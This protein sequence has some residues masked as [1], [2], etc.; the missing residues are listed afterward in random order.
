MGIAA[1]QAARSANRSASPASRKP[2]ASEPGLAIAQDL[3]GRGNLTPLDSLFGAAAIVRLNPTAGF[4][5][6]GNHLGQRLRKYAD[7][8]GVAVDAA[9]AEPALTRLTAKG[10]SSIRAVAWKPDT[11]L[12]KKNRHRAFI[13][14]QTGVLNDLP[15]IV[16][17]QCAQGLKIGGKL[18]AADLMLS[19]SGD[20]AR[21]G[22]GSGLPAPCPFDEHT[23]AL[24]SAGFDVECRYDLTENFMAAVRSGLLQSLGMLQEFRGLEKAG[25]IERACAFAAQ[26]E[27]WKTLY[28]LAEARRLEAIGLLAVRAR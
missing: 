1:N 11:A 9:E 10:K 26:L 27:T 2:S 20:T 22:A 13:A 6:V 7:D 8:T 18:F 3:W 12:F 5:F 28:S 25:R 19:D 21:R 16:Y 14:L 15:G 4:G 23:A 24:K 17:R